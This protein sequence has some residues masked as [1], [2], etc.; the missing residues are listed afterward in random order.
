LEIQHSIDQKSD[1]YIYPFLVSLRMGISQVEVEYKLGVQGGAQDWALSASAKPGQNR[2]NA[3]K[4]K[5]VE[6]DL[7]ME[8]H[9]NKYEVDDAAIRNYLP[10]FK[11]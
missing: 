6:G 5:Q 7:S 2:N 11:C 9:Q 4:L 3:T 8:R 10:K 1:F